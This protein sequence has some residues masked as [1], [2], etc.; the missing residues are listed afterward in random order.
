[1]DSDEE[2]FSSSEIN[3]SQEVSEQQESGSYAHQKIA[4]IFKKEEPVNVQVPEED[5]ATSELDMEAV[6]LK[7]KE[8]VKEAIQQFQ[9]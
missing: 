3:S 7:R 1:V 8:L 4:E 2:F 5:D 6:E 9:K